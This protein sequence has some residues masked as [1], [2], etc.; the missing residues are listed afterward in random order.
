MEKL[1]T[2]SRMLCSSRAAGLALLIGLSTPAV[3]AETNDMIL[4]KL[5]IAADFPCKPKRFKQVV[6]KTEAGEEILL[7]SLMCSQGDRTFS[8]SGTQY[9]EQALKSLSADKILDSTL[10][11]LRAQAHY[12]MRSSERTTHQGF[13]AIRMHFLD[14]KAPPMEMARLSV[15]TNASIIAIGMTW[16]SSSGQPSML[17]SFSG[18]LTIAPGKN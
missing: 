1:M 13:A 10:D 7:T 2:G 16:P 11:N 14:S 4:G 8:L 15:L 3:Q 12:T 5:R 18:S 9:P 6:G 17:A